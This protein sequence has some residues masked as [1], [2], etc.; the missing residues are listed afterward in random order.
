MKHTFLTLGTLFFS[1]LSAGQ[2]RSV[3]QNTY[4]CYTGTIGDHSITAYFWSINGDRQGSYAYDQQR[5]EFIYNPSE[6]RP[7]RL[8]TI[9][10]FIPYNQLRGTLL[11]EFSERLHLY[12][13]F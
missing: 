3:P 9:S 1:L 11:P 12:E 8:G 5:I 10:V 4:Q 13:K 6:V 2:G 7:Y